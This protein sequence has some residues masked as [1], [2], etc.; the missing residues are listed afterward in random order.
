M[1]TNLITILMSTFNGEEYLEQQ[2]NSI[3][4]QTNSNWILYIRDDGS[5]DDTL[6]IIAKYAKDDHRIKIFNN[7]KHQ[8]IGPKR[9]FFEML[10]TLDAS[11]YMFSDQ[12]DVWLPNK[13]ELTIKSM[14][15]IET[16]NE[17]LPCLVHTNL[18]TVDAGLVSLNNNKNDINHDDLK[19]LLLAND[20]TGCTVMINKILR[21]LALNGSD[22]VDVMHDMWLGLLA[23]KFGKINFVS[24]PTMLYR[25]HSR[26]VVGTS[27]SIKDKIKRMNSDSEVNR[28]ITSVNAANS[29]LILYG[30]KMTIAELKLL[31][32]VANYGQN[33]IYNALINSLKSKVFKNSVTATI[34]FYMKLTFNYS[35]LISKK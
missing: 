2:L 33:S 34:A 12:D 31:T 23:T 20:V 11:Y 22:S 25:Q 7:V 26:N 28:I 6:K 8:N 35:K 16:V 9:S 29:L 13:I 30:D 5:I 27:S 19:S 18:T 14:Q 32:T 24:E 3:I 1:G 15:S 10:K 4:S 21:N 17:G